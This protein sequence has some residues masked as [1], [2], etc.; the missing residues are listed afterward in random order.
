MQTF[1]DTSCKV[2]FAKLCDRKMPLTPAD[3]LNDRVL[4]FYEEHALRR[5]RRRTDPGTEFC[6]HRTD[7]RMIR[8]RRWRTS[9]I[10]DE[11]AVPADE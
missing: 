10:A 8:N 6:Q 1:I 3:L 11:D 9:T 4:P 5:C 7:M 2:A